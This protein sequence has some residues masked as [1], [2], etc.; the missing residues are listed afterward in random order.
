VV[1][2]DPGHRHQTLH[3]H[4]S[5]NLACAHL[6]LHAVG[7][8]LDQRQAAR[9][10]TQTAIEHTGQFLQPIAETL[11]EVGEQ[12]AFFQ[13]ALS[14]RPPQ[15]TIEH[16]RGDFAQWPNYRFD[17]ISAEL[18]ESRD[19]LMAINDQKTIRLVGHRDDYDRTLLPGRGERGQQ[20][21]LSLGISCAQMFVPAVELVKFQLHR[22]GTGIKPAEQVTNRDVPVKMR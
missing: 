11:L 13:R 16:Q 1:Q 4:L 8:K 22:G 5:C 7:K 9:H 10:P 18:L 12:P 14:F 2:A 20:L 21:A 19:P 3:G 6:F 17:G 15:R